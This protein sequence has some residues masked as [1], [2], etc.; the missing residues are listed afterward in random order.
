ML[1]TPVLGNIARSYITPY[2]SNTTFIHTPHTG[3][4]LRNSRRSG[5]R[6]KRRTVV[7]S[8]PLLTASQNAQWTDFYSNQMNHL[9]N[10]L[11]KV[12]VVLW[13]N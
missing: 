11:E 7:A 9:L 2:A 8:H 5:K 13:K 3:A 6:S 1:S 12:P 10:P 4:E